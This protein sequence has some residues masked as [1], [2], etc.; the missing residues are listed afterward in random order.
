[1]AF[2]PMAT[3]A[4]ANP[5]EDTGSQNPG[6]RMATK[7]QGIQF[8]VVTVARRGLVLGDNTLFPRPDHKTHV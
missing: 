6:T 1:M 4:L 7:K 2:R 3:Q 8:L 5:Q